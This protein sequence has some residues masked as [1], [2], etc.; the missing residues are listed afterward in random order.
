[1]SLI[2]FPAP[3]RNY[4]C[5]PRAALDTKFAFN[6]IVWSQD[7]CH[8][9]FKLPFGERPQGSFRSMYVRMK[10]G[11]LWTYIILLFSLSKS[12]CV[13]KPARGRS[14][15]FPCTFLARTS[16]PF[17]LSFNETKKKCSASGCLAAAYK[18]AWEVKSDVLGKS[19]SRCDK[20][21]QAKKKELLNMYRGA[22]ESP[23]DP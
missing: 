20:D 21:L 13:S 10:N 14:C 8:T 17:P 11:H 4:L 3:P 5:P 7:P 2:F 19:D 6:N 12:K 22:K 15:D 18:P 16:C 23:M 9:Q 1:M